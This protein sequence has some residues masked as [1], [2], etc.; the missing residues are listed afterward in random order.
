MSMRDDTLSFRPGL[1]RT[2]RHRLHCQRQMSLHA[3]A[4]RTRMC[5]T[6]S[7]CYP[8]GETIRALIGKTIRS[9]SVGVCVSS[10]SVTQTTSNDNT[11]D[12]CDLLGSKYTFLWIYTCSLDRPLPILEQW[13]ITDAAVIVFPLCVPRGSKLLPIKLS[14]CCQ[15][16]FVRC[17]WNI[18][19]LRNKHNNISVSTLL[20]IG[21]VC[22]VWF[23]V[24]RDFSRSAGKLAIWLRIWESFWRS[25]RR[26]Y[27]ISCAI[28]CAIAWAGFN[29]LVSIFIWFCIYIIIPRTTHLNRT[30]HI[31]LS[32][33]T[34]DDGESTDVLSLVIYYW[35]H[36]YTSVSQPTIEFRMKSLRFN[37]HAI[38]SSSSS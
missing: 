21:V 10:E 12:N 28:H 33:P 11:L 36:T 22:L 19:V 35:S 4:H 38:V 3:S 15:P 7:A 1:I 32:W 16:R 26:W 34:L 6:I 5:A 30:T 17:I 24:Q 18:S 9:H 29:R 27:R 13:S 31:T 20:A 23:S 14:A 8:P 37:S 2:D 25:G